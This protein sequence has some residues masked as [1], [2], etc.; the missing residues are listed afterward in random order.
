MLIS[1]LC[2]CRMSKYIGKISMLNSKRL[3]K[4][5]LKYLWYLFATLTTDIVKRGDCDM[6]YVF[7]YLKL[8]I[9]HLL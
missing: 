2:A 8:T 1:L 3:L 5:L 9:Q 4:K 7:D 6:E